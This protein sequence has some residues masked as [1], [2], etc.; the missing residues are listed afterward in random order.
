MSRRDERNA[1]KQKRKRAASGAVA[2]GTGSAPSTLPGP[3]AMSVAAAPA[4][5]SDPA[6]GAVED[7][8]ADTA[9]RVSGEHGAPKDE[10][11]GG[12]GTSGGDQVG[13]GEGQ[14][15]HEDTSQEDQNARAGDEDEGND[16]KDEDTTGGANATGDPHGEDS[17]SSSS[18]GDDEDSTSTDPNSSEKP[19]PSFKKTPEINVTGSMT[20]DGV[21]VTVSHSI[22]LPVTGPLLDEGVRH[23]VN[24]IVAMVTALQTGSQTRPEMEALYERAQLALADIERRLVDTVLAAVTTHAAEGD[25]RNAGGEGEETENSGSATSNGSTEEKPKNEVH[26]KELGRRNQRT[27]RCLQM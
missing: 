20:G 11:Q 17:S 2:G 23:L 27:Y 12:E 21:C 7:G 3:P 4:V 6:T 14:E 5:V 8:G 26:E 16:K 25:A 19:M 1:K 18:N 10:Y 13:D 9:G 24:V 15:E 22:I